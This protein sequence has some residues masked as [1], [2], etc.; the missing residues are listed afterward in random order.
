MSYFVEN[1]GD[2]DPF[3]LNYDTETRAVVLKANNTVA[4]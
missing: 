4:I 2:Q 3:E 1:T